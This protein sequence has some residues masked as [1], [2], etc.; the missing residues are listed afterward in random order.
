MT[1][2]IEIRKRNGATPSKRHVA[3]SKASERSEAALAV[4]ETKE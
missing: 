2:T 3:S 4:C 1:V